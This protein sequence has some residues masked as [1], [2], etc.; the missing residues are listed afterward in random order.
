MRPAASPT[1]DPVNEVLG[2]VYESQA[3]RELE[4][5]LFA[6][7]DS[8]GR[9]VILGRWLSKQGIASSPINEGRYALYDGGVNV[10]LGDNQGA[11][12]H[13][14]C[15]KSP[16]LSDG[17]RKVTQPKLSAY[18]YD[19]RADS[20]Y[21]LGQEGEDGR[22]YKATWLPPSR[23][24]ELLKELYQKVADQMSELSDEIKSLGEAKPRDDIGKLPMSAS[25]KRYARLR[26]M[27]DLAPGRKFRLY[28]K[29]VADEV[30]RGVVKG[31]ANRDAAGAVKKTF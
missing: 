16:T 11:I 25:G 27:K 19:K 8:Q 5:M 4:K 20:G 10:K 12:V 31:F 30:N 9:S 28:S 21:D 1:F 7:S 22:F 15:L 13:L 14:K 18:V 17:K 3:D 24:V 29:M 26:G 6:A 23:L 2:R